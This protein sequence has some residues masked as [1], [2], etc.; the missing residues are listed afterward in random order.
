[1]TS[2]ELKFA[3]AVESVLNRIPEPEY[4]QLLVEA[5]IVLSLISE[6]EVAKSLGSVIAVENIVHKANQIFLQDQVTT[7]LFLK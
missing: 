4:R 5:L 6:H 1:M 2:G 3:L 7:P